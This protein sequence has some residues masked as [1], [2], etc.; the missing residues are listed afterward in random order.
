MLNIYKWAQFFKNR[1]IKVDIS[2]EVEHSDVELKNKYFK[3]LRLLNDNIRGLYEE[4]LNCKKNLDELNARYEEILDWTEFTDLKKVTR[5][6][7][8]KQAI[9]YRLLLELYQDKLDYVDIYSLKDELKTDRRCIEKALTGAKDHKSWQ[10]GSPEI[11]K[12]CEKC[13]LKIGKRRK[14]CFKPKG[15]FEIISRLNVYISLALFLI[16]KTLTELVKE[17]KYSSKLVG[18]LYREYSIKQESSKHKSWKLL[19]FSEYLSRMGFK[20][21]ELTRYEVEKLRE[22]YESLKVIME[23]IESLEL[24]DKMFSKCILK[25]VKRKNSLK[26]RAKETLKT[27][28][29]ALKLFIKNNET[30][31]KVLS[32]LRSDE[33]FWKFFWQA[34]EVYMNYFRHH[35]E[36]GKKV[37]KLLEML[38]SYLALRYLNTI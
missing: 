25:G 32:L 4:I 6:L 9:C 33:I 5:S 12:I 7:S 30:K 26:R 37:N 16:E 31:H 28:K 10:R 34:P 23:F 14:V 21:K 15:L 27:R 38:I 17:A 24:T 3:S 8:H 19:D 1:A 18:I 36:V 35:L 11:S 2:K 20:E 13:Y 22:N 29:E